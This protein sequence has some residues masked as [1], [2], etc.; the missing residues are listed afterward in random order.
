MKNPQVTATSAQPNGPFDRLDAA[1]VEADMLATRVIHLA[2]ELLGEPRNEDDQ[3]VKP[4]PAGLLPR[5]HARADDLMDKLGDADAAL[6]RIR[7]RL[8]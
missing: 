3:S 2:C 1:L 6:N 5:F 7:A 8:P 4:M